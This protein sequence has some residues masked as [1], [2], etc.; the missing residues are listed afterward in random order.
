MEPSP[1]MSE[2]EA[3]ASTA[4]VDRANAAAA[5]KSEQALK[6]AL[7]EAKEAEVGALQLQARLPPGRGVAAVRSAAE[8]ASALVSETAVSLAAATFASEAAEKVAW[9][10]EGEAA[11]LLL[12]VP[13][14]LLILSFAIVTTGLNVRPEHF[15][16]AATST[17]G[18]LYAKGLAFTEPDAEAMPEEL[19][20]QLTKSPQGSCHDAGGNGCSFKESPLAKTKKETGDRFNWRRW[21]KSCSRLG[22][23]THY[24][25]AVATTSL[26][27]KYVVLFTIV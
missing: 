12:D 1:Q 2:V 23:A 11:R 14:S 22:C 3:Q 27:K 8:K 13:V 24:N 16:R 17:V 5:Y 15:V 26:Q 21:M 18:S 19:Q 10:A 25:D 4:T 6:K 7:E 20:S 9:A